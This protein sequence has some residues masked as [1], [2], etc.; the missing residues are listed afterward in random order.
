M[1]PDQGLCDKQQ[2]G[3]KGKKNRLTYLF[4]VNAD[5]SKKLAPLIIGKSYKP[6]AFGGKTG[7]QLSFDYHNNAKAWMT[8]TIYQEWLDDWD[9]KL[10]KEG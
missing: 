3:I 7:S 2:V 9:T 5:G 10:R 4:V 8:G 1:P 6:R